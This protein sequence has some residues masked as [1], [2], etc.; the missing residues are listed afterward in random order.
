[1][2]TTV[3][4]PALASREFLWLRRRTGEGRAACWGDRMAVPVTMGIVFLH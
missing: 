1:M 2:C 3:S 4:D